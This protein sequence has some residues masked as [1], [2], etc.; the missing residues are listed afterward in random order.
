MKVLVKNDNVKFTPWRIAG[1]CALLFLLFLLIPAAYVL[2]RL[3]VTGEA[4]EFYSSK[5]FPVISMLPIALSGMFL[6][7]LTEMAVVVGSLSL[8]FLIVLFF[9]KCIK[10]FRKRSMMH[11]LHFVYVVLRAVAVIGIVAALVFECML[12]LNYNRTS[13]RQRMHL[14]SEQPRP[15]EDYEEAMLWAYAGMVEARNALGEDYNGVAHMSTSFETTVFDANLAVS[16]LDYYHNLGMSGNY[17]RAK[18]VWLSR[19]WRYTDIVGMYDAFLGESNI[20]TD[21]IDILH[22]PVTVCHEISHAKGYGS[23]TDCTTIAVLSCIN[24]ERADFRYAGYYYIFMRLWSEVGE[25]ASHEGYEIPDFLSMQS[26]A[27]VIRDIRAYNAYID[28]FKTGPIA[29][30][31]ARFSEDANNAFLESNGQEGGTDTYIV[32]Q[33]SYVEYYCRYVRRDA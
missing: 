18:A 4:A 24:S 31:I 21:Y 6:F 26:F 13:V 25:Y 10:I 15:Y 32:P 30:F 9:I 27:P 7:S 11:M 23:E 19:Y 3:L 8:L 14:Y 29:D 33:D 1:R 16:S 20:N 17:V 22:F 5:V 28:S 2:P 12:G